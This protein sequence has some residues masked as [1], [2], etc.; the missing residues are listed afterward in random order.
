MSKDAKLSRRGFLIGGATALALVPFL[1]SCA[2]RTGGGGGGG[3]GGAGGDL[4]FWD[5][6]WGAVGYN[7]AAK[8]ITA[9]FTASD[10]TTATYQ[11]VQWANF[12][13]TFASAVAAKVGPAV[14][15]A[16][17][18]AYEIADQGGIAY[19]DD[20]IEKFK[21]DGR[22]DDFLPGTVE[23]LNTAAGQVG[24]PFVVDVRPIWYRKSLLEEAGVN[25]PTTWDE[26]LDAG[27]ALKKNGVYG[28]GIG[29]GTGANLGYQAM[30][31]LMINNG[32][33]LFDEDGNPDA[34]IA[35]N[36]EAMEF[37]QELVKEGIIDPA[38]VS[39]T[40][41]NI[42][43]QWQNKKFGIGYHTPAL[44]TR[45]GDTADDML[46]LAPPTSP[47]GKTGT[48]VYNNS[49]VMYTDTPSQAVSE[50]FVEYLLDNL[51]SLWKDGHMQQ[52]PA[53]KSIADLPEVRANEQFGRVIDEWQPIAK[54]FA[55]RGDYS[56]AS[57]AAIDASQGLFQFTQAMLGGSASPREALERLQKDLERVAG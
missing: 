13:Q 37:V 30:V 49:I 23:S 32:G 43:A 9:G 11:T 10:G 17:F 36:I 19:A 51:P 2:P 38:S 52:M 50:E 45:V 53:M 6:P 56:F 48:L 41:E 46:V 20:L 39:Y 31:A 47:R 7:D 22:Y 15:T 55:S 14:S 28:F 29:T 40:D 4:K 5:L 8:K 27:R 24:I 33:G 12:G 21:R 54:T 26:W 57:L 44:N 25:P 16:S 42:A 3:G 34:V 1:A 18:T 35:E